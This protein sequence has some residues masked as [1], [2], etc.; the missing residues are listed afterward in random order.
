MKPKI[1]KS[2]EELAQLPDSTTHRIQVKDSCAWVISMQ[3]P[4]GGEDKGKGY[5][6]LSSYSFDKSQN[7]Q[8]TQILKNCG[9]NVRLLRTDTLAGLKRMISAQLT[10]TK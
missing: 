3:K 9:F 4:F 5:Q 7:K 2:W 6:Y 8:A 10:K 1:I